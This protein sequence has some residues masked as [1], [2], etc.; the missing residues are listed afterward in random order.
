MPFVVDD[1]AAARFAVDWEGR[2]FSQDLFHPPD[3]LLVLE[4]SGCA[5]GAR[6]SI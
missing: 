6:R 1:I 2:H 3:L 4:A 5:A